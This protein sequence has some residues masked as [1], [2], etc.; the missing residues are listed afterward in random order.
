MVNRLLMSLPETTVSHFAEQLG[1]TAD[2]PTEVSVSWRAASLM[3]LA[4]TMFFPVLFMYGAPVLARTLF[5][6]A[7]HVELDRK[8]DAAQLSGFSNESWMRFA[9]A[10]VAQNP[11]SAL[12]NLAIPLANEDLRSQATHLARRA[13]AAAAL[14]QSAGL[15]AQACIAMILKNRER[16]MPDE[17]KREYELLKSGFNGRAQ[18]ARMMA[19]QNDLIGEFSL[20]PGI[21]V[22]LIVLFPAIWVISALVFRGGLVVRLMGMVI[23]RADGR[24][25][26]RIQCAWRAI[27]TWLPPT[28]LLLLAVW[29]D[30]MYWQAWAA[31]GQP[32]KWLESAAWA[33]WF[34]AL[35]LLPCYILLALWY[36]ARGPHDR[37]AETYLLPR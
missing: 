18:V 22:A 28:A 24:R 27:L 19:Q 21:V 2:R 14:D 6:V 20:M 9:L 8:A 31:T 36:P 13:E 25:A 10:E 3:I 33:S 4:A 12:T 35:V 32:G 17:E 5:I 26:L 37:L 34:S 23:L 7:K 30:A 15:V 29:L 16:F 11:G 1:A